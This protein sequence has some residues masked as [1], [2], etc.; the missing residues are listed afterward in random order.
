MHMHNDYK[1]L[2]GLGLGGSAKQGCS[3]GAKQDAAG[4]PPEVFQHS[5]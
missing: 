1:Y 5:R 3:K 4:E 2:I